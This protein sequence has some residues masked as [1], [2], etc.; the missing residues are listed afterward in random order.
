MPPRITRRE[1]ARRKRVYAVLGGLLLVSLTLLALLERDREPAVVAEAVVTDPEPPVVNPASRP[2]SSTSST[3]R[4]G[5]E[6]SP[7]PPPVK[8]SPTS[9]VA[10]IIDDVGY[11]GQLDGQAAAIPFP[12]TYSVLPGL[13]SSSTSAV[14]L[15]SA[16]CEVMLHLPMEPE[17]YPEKNPGPGALFTFMTPEEI[18]STIRQDILSVPGARGV[19]NHMGSHFSVREDLLKVVFEEL[20]RHDL[21]FI[22]SRTTTD[23]AAQKVAR[24]LGLKNGRRSVFLDN[25]EDPAAIAKQL[26]ELFRVA[27][28]DHRA[29]GIGHYRQSTLDVLAT[30]VPRLCRLH[31]DVELVYASDVVR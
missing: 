20:R 15:I 10:I 16:G 21:Y 27:R 28:R 26:E 24:R 12:V 30:E 25:S 13:D 5:V 31:P 1:R 29:V 19:N 11:H 22:D 23:T 7:P 3:V 2:E 14:R 6:P 17:R 9:Q 4:K 18:R 8:K